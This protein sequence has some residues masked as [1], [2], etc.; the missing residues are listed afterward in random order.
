MAGVVLVTEFVELEVGKLALFGQ[1][2]LPGGFFIRF[3]V[4]LYGEAQSLLRD[5]VFDRGGAR[6]LF[7]PF[8]GGFGDAE[9]LVEPF[10]LRDQLGLAACDIEF[11]LRQAASTSTR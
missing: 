9:A 5:G 8:P 10:H 4:F 6:V 3:L 1:G 2:N 11:G 7:G